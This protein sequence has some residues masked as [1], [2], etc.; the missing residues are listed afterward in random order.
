MSEA[1]RNLIRSHQEVVKLRNLAQKLE[2]MGRSRCSLKH[3]RM[4]CTVWGFLPPII[5][6]HFIVL[7]LSPTPF[8]MLISIS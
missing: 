8:S 2:L 1:Q 3:T 7:N 6:D 4:G 5:A